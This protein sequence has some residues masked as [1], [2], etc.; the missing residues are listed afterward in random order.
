LSIKANGYE[1]LLLV[2]FPTTATTGSEKDDLTEC[3]KCCLALL[4][5]AE[6][7][8]TTSKVLQA[9]DTNG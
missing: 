1:L 8:L 6:R 3:E 7:R 9:F 2:T 5:G 4:A